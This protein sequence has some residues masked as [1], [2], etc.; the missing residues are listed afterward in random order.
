MAQTLAESAAIPYGQALTAEEME[1]LTQELFKLAEANYTPAGKPTLTCI[2][3]D[4]IEKR[5]K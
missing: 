2:A 5:F 3:N 4:E 1:Y